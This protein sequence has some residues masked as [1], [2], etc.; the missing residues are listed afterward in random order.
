VRAAAL[1]VL[2][3]ALLDGLNP[4]T[5]VPA[6]V[7]AVR[8]RGGLLVALFTIGVVAPSFAAGII[9]IAGPGQFLINLIPHVGDHSKHLLEMLAGV[10]LAVLAAVLWTQRHRVART[11][12]RP[13]PGGALGTVGVGAGIMVAEL[14]TAFPYFAALAAI[15]AAGV[16][17]VRQVELVALFNL[18][19]VLP[20]LVIAVVRALAGKR[21]AEVLGRIRGVLDRYIGVALPLVVGLLAVGFFATGL[22]GYL[23]E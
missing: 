10:V 12:T 5:I 1:L 13:L 18:A 16:S 8:E 20:L 21:S 9:V 14:P 3:I 2:G 6:L 22:V 7:L 11:M 17:F 4:S 19:F 15:I 23:Q